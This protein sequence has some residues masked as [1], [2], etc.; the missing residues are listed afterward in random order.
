MLPQ[1]RIQRWTAEQIVD[2]PVPEV[3]EEHVD[4]AKVSS[5]NRVPQ[6]FQEQSAGQ[7]RISERRVEQTVDVP[8]KCRRRCPETVEAVEFRKKFFDMYTDRG[9]CRAAL[10][11]LKT[12]HS[13]V[14]VGRWEMM[15]SCDCASAAPFSLLVG[16][17][18]CPP[19]TWA[20]SVTPSSDSPVLVVLLLLRHVATTP[21]S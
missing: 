11:R 1:N 12:Q 7:E 3:V 4:I 13:K 19:N 17:G 6:L 15:R 18:I 8:N 16:R 2:M 20:S 21:L 14:H 9:A 5:Q 10:K